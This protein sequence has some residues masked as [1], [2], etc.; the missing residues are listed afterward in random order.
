MSLRRHIY[1]NEV[2]D[3]KV[4]GYIADEHRPKCH[5]VPRAFSLLLAPWRNATPCHTHGVIAQG[6]GYHMLTYPGPK[7]CVRN[8]GEN[9]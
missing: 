3:P 7:P 9:F 5:D 1:R 2:L 4:H 8:T 6:P